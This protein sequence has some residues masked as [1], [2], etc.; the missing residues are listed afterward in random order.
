MLPRVLYDQVIKKNSTCIVTYIDYTAAFD[1]VSH[2]FMDATL[3]KAG[4]STKSRAIF[5]AIYEA[6]TGIARVRGI[7]GT[8]IY[9]EAFNVGR[10]VI[11]GDIMS[12]VL[13]ILALDQIIQQYD[14]AGKG[15]KCGKILRS[16]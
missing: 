10:G 15:V 6:A 1:S 14:T 11:Q 9:S 8:T 3:A 4:A 7:D 2:K 12:P 16:N 5:R 13:F